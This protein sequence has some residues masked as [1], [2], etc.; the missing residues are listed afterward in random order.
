MKRRVEYY[1][2]TEGARVES[3]RRYEV[4]EDVTGSREVGDYYRSNES[5]RMT[6][7]LDPANGLVVHDVQQYEEWLKANNLT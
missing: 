4:V 5:V 3:E 7:Y 2:L 6:L 1:S